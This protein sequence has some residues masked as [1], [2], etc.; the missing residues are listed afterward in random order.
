MLPKAVS[1]AACV[2]Y[3]PITFSASSVSPAPMENWLT[4][5]LTSR[6]WKCMPEP[7]CP[8]AILGENDT[9]MP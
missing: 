5:S 4:P 2:R 1:D 9:S 7:A 8:T 3:P 6:V